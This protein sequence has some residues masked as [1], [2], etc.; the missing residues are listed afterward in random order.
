M[1]S[2]GSARQSLA[3]HTGSSTFHG[4]FHDAFYGAF[5]G[6]FHGAFHGAFY[7]AFHGEFYGRMISEGCYFFQRPRS[8]GVAG[9]ARADTRWVLQSRR[10]VGR[11]G[12]AILGPA[13]VPPAHWDCW[14]C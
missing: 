5:Y 8:L 14:Y 7:G 4:A 2:A 9:T 12:R 10:C 6:A 1:G 13:G 3:A 11:Y